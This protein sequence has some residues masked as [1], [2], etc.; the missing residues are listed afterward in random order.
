MKAFAQPISGIIRVGPDTD[1]YGKP[2]DYAVTY[3]STEPGIC[4]L[5]GLKGDG[6][7]ST[8]HRRAVMQVVRNLGFKSVRWE[9]KKDTGNKEIALD[10]T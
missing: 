4:M 7:V 5:M 10:L 6:K 9:R 8:A 1:Q 3:S 2:W